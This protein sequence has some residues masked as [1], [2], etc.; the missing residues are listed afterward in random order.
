[1]IRLRSYA[2]AAALLGTAGLASGCGLDLQDVPLPHLVSGPT[3]QITV[4]FA[5]ALNLPVDAPVKLD[6]ATVGEVREVTAGDYVAEVDLA[7]SEAVRLRSSSRA[8]IR[9]TAPMGTAFVQL[10]PGRKGRLLG[11]GD[12]L[13][14]AATS[15]APDVTDLLASLST[16]VTGGSFRDVATVIEELNVALTGNAG[17]VHSLL[18]RLDTAVTHMN[19]QFPALDRLTVALDRLTDRLAEDLPTI[20]ASMTELTDLVD[21]LDRQRERMMTTLEAITRFGS[22]A[23][24]FTASVR[25]DAVGALADLRTVLTSL[26]GSRDDITGLLNGLAAFAKGSDAATP[27]DFVNFDLTFLLDLDALTQLSSGDDP[28]VRPGQQGGAR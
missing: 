26:V 11:E 1:M 16:I 14:T 2:A 8:E 24:P 28:R 15:T 25:D 12:T 10:L 6:G 5:D 23:T 4:E 9:L 20:T 27:G 17:R 21:V 7:L 3:Y 13:T 22:V 19:D 18:A